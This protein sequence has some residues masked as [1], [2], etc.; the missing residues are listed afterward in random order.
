MFNNAKKNNLDKDVEKIIKIG[1]NVESRGENLRKRK[2]DPL[3]Y[4]YKYETNV[5]SRR[6]MKK[7]KPLSIREKLEIMKRVLIRYESQKDLAKEFR[8][9]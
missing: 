2:K 5:C 9:S 4:D 8:I 7:R 3:N 1:K 6:R